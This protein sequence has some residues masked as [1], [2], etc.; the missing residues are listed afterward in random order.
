MNIKTVKEIESFIKA[1]N[2]CSASVAIK[3]IRYIEH[4]HHDFESAHAKG[5]RLMK[6]EVNKA[7]KSLVSPAY[8]LK[9]A[10]SKEYELQVNNL[11]AAIPI[12]N[13][14]TVTE[15]LIARVL[16]IVAEEAPDKLDIIRKRIEGRDDLPS[17]DNDNG[18]PTGG[19]PGHDA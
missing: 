7:T 1:T 5:A 4:L 6:A 10:V 9:T 15:D 17:N 19:N 16:G 3:L 2:S 12:P 8:N 13:V 18:Q 11:V 14:T